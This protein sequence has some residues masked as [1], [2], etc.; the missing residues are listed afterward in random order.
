MNLAAG[1]HI[2]GAKT[3]WQAMEQIGRG[4]YA[5]VYKAEDIN[6]NALVAIKIAVKNDVTRKAGQREADAIKLLHEESSKDS[7]FF[8][9]LLDDFYYKLHYCLV[10][11]FAPKDMAQLL[12]KTK[13]RGG[14][15]LS[16]IRNY[17]EQLLCALRHLQKCGL[18][19]TD[20][21]PDNILLYNE[22]TLIK[23]CDFGT[24]VKVKDV[25]IT[26]EHGSRWY[27]APEIMLGFLRID[28]NADMWSVGVTLF[29]L[30]GS[31]HL[32]KGENNHEMLREQQECRGHIPKRI[33]LNMPSGKNGGPHF[34]SEAE[35]YQ[36]L[37]RGKDGRVTTKKYSNQALPGKSIK[38]RLAAT[39]RQRPT[40][41]QP[42]RLE[43]SN[44]VDFLERCLLMDAWQRI[45]VNDAL[46]HPFIVP[47]NPIK[48]ATKRVVPNQYYPKF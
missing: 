37:I 46:A 16:R 30:T 11:E 10:F 12:A 13:N 21:K 33:L 15:P 39:M 29:E 47:G 42:G 44:L 1:E 38:E 22:D 24:A 36:F 35:Q 17:T 5:T 28:G 6:R 40:P 45:E 26:P 48:K 27:R 25:E 31:G 32:F 43:L 14:L 3:T 19:H 20:I 8:V 41:L 4:S 34:T 2:K 23:I 7:K 18:I 9:N